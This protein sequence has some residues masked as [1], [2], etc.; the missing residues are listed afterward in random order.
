MKRILG[1]F[2]GD[3]SP[4]MQ[5][6]DLSDTEAAPT[7]CRNLRLFISTPFP[8]TEATLPIVLAG[9]LSGSGCENQDT[10]GGQR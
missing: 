9:A 2:G 7:A 3:T 10:Y 8:Q 4:L 5:G 6:N 1:L